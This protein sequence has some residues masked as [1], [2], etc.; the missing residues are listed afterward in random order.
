MGGDRDGERQRESA[1]DPG[2][3]G[4]QRGRFGDD[5]ERVQDAGPAGAVRTDAAAERRT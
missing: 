4:Q 3:Q 2:D 1:E 5:A